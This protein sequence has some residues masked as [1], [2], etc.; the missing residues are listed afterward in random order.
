MGVSEILLIFAIKSSNMK[1][2]WKTFLYLFGMGNNPISIDKHSDYEAIKGDWGNVGK[3]I[4][5]AINNYHKR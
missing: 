5:I 3:D 1:I 2:F 4:S